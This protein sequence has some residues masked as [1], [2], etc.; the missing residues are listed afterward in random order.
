MAIDNGKISTILISIFGIFAA[1]IIADPSLLGQ[2]GVPAQY[3]SVII[4]ILIVIY[5]AVFPRTSEAEP[6]ESEDNIA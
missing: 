5:N 4:G 2:F 3:I 6:V 1:A